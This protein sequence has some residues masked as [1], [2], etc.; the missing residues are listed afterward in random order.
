MTCN[1]TN[2]GDEDM[3]KSLTTEDFENYVSGNKVTCPRCQ[4][5]IYRSPYNCVKPWI[6]IHTDSFRNW[7]IKPMAP[8]FMHG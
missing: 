4:E 6:C 3:G 2:L 8:G 1:V 5:K 7:N